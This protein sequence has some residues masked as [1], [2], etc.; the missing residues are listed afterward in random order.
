MPKRINIIGE[1]YGRLTVLKEVEQIGYERRF[2]CKCICGNEKIVGMSQLRTG[3]TKSCGCLNKEITSQKNTRDLTGK[4]F[5]KL[6]VIGRSKEK[7]Q[8]QTKAIWQCK[9]DCGNTLDV[10]STYLTSGD[11]TSCGCHRKQLGIE[12]Q[13]NN[14]KNFWNDGVFSPILKSKRRSDNTTG[15]KGVSLNR[16]NG[17]YR[18]QISIKGKKIYLGEYPTIEQAAKAREAGEEKYHSPYLED[19]ND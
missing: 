14:K 8:T 9:C 10:L 17:K 16:R 18:A 3:K 5:G 7:H 2:L 13:Q 4:R 19:R 11:T 1:Q 12:L 15:V 6:T